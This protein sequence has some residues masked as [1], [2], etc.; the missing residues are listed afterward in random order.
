MNTTTHE[1]YMQRCLQLASK[2]LGLT[3]PNPMVGCVIVYEG[4][5][6]GEG[7]HQKAGDAHAEVNAINSV[8]DKSLLPKSTLYVSLEPCSHYGKTPPC[9]DLILKMNIKSIVIGTIDFNSEVHGKGIEHLQKNGCKVTLGILEDECRTLNKRF[10]TFHQKKR[11]YIILKWAETKDGF[12]FPDVEISNNKKPIW[13]SN[14]YSLQQVH[15]WRTE[16][17]SILVGTKTAITDNPK[18]NARNYFG[19]NPLRLVI[20]KDLKLNDDYSLL[21]G[22]VATIAFTQIKTASD[23]KNIRFIVVDFN[24][25]I[26]DQICDYLYSIEIQSIIVEGGAMT[27]QSFIDENLW[28]E[29]RVFTG[30]IFFKNGLKAPKINRKQINIT[31]IPSPERQK[32]KNILTTFFND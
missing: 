20:D 14:T 28:D 9:T 24:K 23:K 25:N 19:S 8:N 2:G 30:D 10:F 5:I 18:L 29:A 12:I 6:I 7:W 27:L 31:Q 16:E 21:D 11:P 22:E 1:F 3:Y 32:N 13:I 17:Q 15:K 26:V 4:K